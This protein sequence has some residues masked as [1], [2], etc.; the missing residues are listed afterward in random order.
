M[1]Q[2]LQS[3]NGADDEDLP[4]FLARSWAETTARDFR[5]AR[6]KR[7]RFVSVDR[8]HERMDPVEI[9]W[10][11]VIR[12]FSEAWTA[13]CKLIIS[14]EQFELWLA[15][16]YVARG[17]EE[18]A[19]LP[20]LKELRNAVVHLSESDIDEDEWVAR[21]S[22][23]RQLTYGVGALPQGELA[24]WLNG[25]ADV[26]GVISADALE[27]YVAALLGELDRELDDYASD[28]WAEMRREDW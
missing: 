9:S 10:H 13:E 27:Q 18:P 24:I 1:P 17:R 20:Y 6:R 3:F 25:T 4:L 2:P 22:G 8:A 5:E 16:L 21:P 19:R 7:Q 14:A 12:A 15:K 28:W 26:L 11:D 23:Y